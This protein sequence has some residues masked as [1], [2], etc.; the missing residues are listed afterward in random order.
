MCVGA[1]APMKG[2]NMCVSVCTT[3]Q[4]REYTGCKENHR[5]QH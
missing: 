1:S 3:V 5:N 2:G 4:E